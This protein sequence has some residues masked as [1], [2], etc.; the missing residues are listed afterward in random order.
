MDN[1]THLE[2]E[3]AYS[4]IFTIDQGNILA[5]RPLGDY[6]EMLAD[7]GFFRLHR[8]FAINLSH[9]KRFEK[10][11]GGYVI[12]TGDHKIPVASRKREVLL[13]L[14]DELGH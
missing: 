9:I 13:N 1:I 4:K 10:Q 7:F 14:L 5:S 2:S 11:E 6:E 8:S 3:G 12:L